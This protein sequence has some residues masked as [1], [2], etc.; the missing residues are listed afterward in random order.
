[1]KIILRVDDCGWTPQKQPDTNLIYFQEWRKQFG[2]V[3]YPVVYGF[4]PAM[5]D[6]DEIRW[7]MRNLSK[8]ERLAVHGWDHEKDAVLTVADMARGREH[9][10]FAPV[11]YI[12]PFNKY[13]VDTMD[14]WS[15]VCDY[16]S[17]FFGG[18]VGEDHNL[19][20]YPMRVGQTIHLPACRQLYERAPKVLE[21]LTRYL[22]T[23]Q[24]PL[25]LTLHLTWDW[26]FHGLSALFDAI[27]D[28]LVGPEYVQKWLGKATLNLKELSA[29]HYAAY[30]WICQRLRPADRVLDV[31]S[32]YGLLPAFMALR[33]CQV[34][35]L[36]SDPRVHEYQQNIANA[37][38][39][40][41]TT[42]HADIADAPN[43]AQFPFDTITACWSIQHN[44]DLHTQS[45]I[46]RI[47]GGCLAPGGQLIVVSSFAS[48]ATFH[49]TDRADPQVVLNMEDHDRVIIEPSGLRLVERSF[50]TYGHGTTHY[51]WCPP[52]SAS[53][54]CYR[55]VKS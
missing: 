31:G 41:I 8:E 23:D 51:D 14:C 34:C 40:T 27:K 39:V 21:N 54:T 55:L 19:G 12:P 11:C 38:G 47:L 48:G 2:I 32:R 30:D 45:K 44:C 22:D 20:H 3:G 10:K 35:A 15:V 17:Y 24:C 1:M 9:L 25:V 43:V 7:L 37:R 4:I 50:F 36:D 33:G 5:V 13:G 53:A 46:A 49:Q 18:F 29:P 42:I 26:E 6:D 28:H 52:E 16:P